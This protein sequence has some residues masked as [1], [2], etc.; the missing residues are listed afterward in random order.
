MLEKRINLRDLGGLKNI[1]GQ[2]V[3][4]KRLLR[5]ADLA[6]LS[7]EDQSVL[8]NQYKLK[9]VVDFRTLSEMEAEPDVQMANVKEV[10]DP[11]MDESDDYATSLK[12]LESARSEDYLIAA[13]RGFVADDFSR[14]AYAEFFKILLNNQEGATLWHCAVGKDRTGFGAALILSALDVPKATIMKD[15]LLTNKFRQQKNEA[16][17]ARL[18]QRGDEAMLHVMK[19]MME[20]REVY[21][22]SAF[23][24]VDKDFGDMTGYLKDGLGLSAEDLSD[25]KKMYLN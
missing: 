17:Y 18:A 4:T 22:N 6:K 10:R 15:Y 21:L 20:A 14:K 5:S 7:K 23:E 12:N 25:L 2:T 13:Y 8:I 19:A 3:Q 9:V 1:E 24:Q 11:I 16:F